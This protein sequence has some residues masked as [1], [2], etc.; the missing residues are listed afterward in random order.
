MSHSKLFFIFLFFCAST[1]AAET[2]CT[3]PDNQ[4]DLNICSSQEF[5]KVDNKL[6]RI[7]NE[8]RATLDENRKRLL[9]AAELAWIKYR[10]YSCEL[11]WPK[12]ESG[13]IGPLIRNDCMIRMTQH[14][15]KE[16]KILANCTLESPVNCA[17]LQ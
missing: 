12:G 14:R 11:E 2:D 15:I 6:N 13:S 17:E 3:K 4:T 1:F 9:K 16:I 10:D 7:Y 8:Y 5:D